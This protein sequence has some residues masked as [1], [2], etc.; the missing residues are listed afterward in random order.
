VTGRW[1]RGSDRW[2]VRCAACIRRDD[3]G[4]TCAAKNE[5]HRGRRRLGKRRPRSAGPRAVHGADAE[6][7]VRG[8]GIATRRRGAERGRSVLVLLSLGL[9]TTNSK[10]LNRSAQNFEYKSCRSHY[11]L[12]LSQ[13]P[14]GVYLS[15]F[16][17]RSLPT[18]NVNLCQ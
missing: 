13:R 10:I 7:G 6:A 18:L 9:N 12:Q 11:P 8:R 3:E 16:C 17:K 14:Y 15:R 5:A 1:A 4:D 2:S